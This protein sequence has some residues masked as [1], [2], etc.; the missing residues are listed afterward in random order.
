MIK[1]ISEKALQ[2]ANYYS[3]RPVIVLTIDLAEYGEVKTSEIP[4]F[5]EGLLELMPSLDEHRCS[6]GVKG[7]FITRMKEGTLLGY[8]IEHI[9]LE[10]QY[11]AYMDVGFG[12]NKDHRTGSET[13]D[14][15]V[16]LSRPV[17]E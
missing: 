17:V 7:G 16:P 5:V 2:G 8:V 14:Q 13:P 11:I 1:I 6:E 10:L 12:N 15:A 3:Y 4:G 9:A